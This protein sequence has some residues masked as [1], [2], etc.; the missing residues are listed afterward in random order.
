MT[1]TTT[2]CVTRGVTNRRHK[3]RLAARRVAVVERVALVNA[4]TVRVTVSARVTRRAIRT[5]L[6]RVV[7]RYLVVNRMGARC[8][9]VTVTRVTRVTDT[10]EG[11]RV[12]V[13]V[14]ACTH[15]ATV[16][17]VRRIR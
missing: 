9:G 4:R 15:L 17:I 14:A 7:H 2:S 16:E 3:D 1:R 8:R 5:V 6:G 13:S 11:R 10:L 12:V